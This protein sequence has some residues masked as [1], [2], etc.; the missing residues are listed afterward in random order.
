MCTWENRRGMPPRRAPT[1]PPGPPELTVEPDRAREIVNGLI[2]E[3]HELMATTIVTTPEQFEQW[4][5]N[6]KRW[7][8]KGFEN[9]RRMWDQDSYAETLAWAANYSIQGAFWQ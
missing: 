3:G 1:P 6:C 8:N 9:L 5:A 2:Q 4:I 7:S